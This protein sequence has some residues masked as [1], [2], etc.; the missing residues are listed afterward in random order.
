MT[1]IWPEGGRRCASGAD[2]VAFDD[3]RASRIAF[4]RTRASATAP[5]Q[6]AALF[7]PPR[8]PPLR[9]WDVASIECSCRRQGR[10][11]VACLLAGRRSDETQRCDGGIQRQAQ[12]EL[13]LI[14]LCGWHAVSTVLVGEPC[15][16]GL[17]TASHLHDHDLQLLEW[18]QHFRSIDEQPLLSLA[19]RWQPLDLLLAG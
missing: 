5:L 10:D 9:L 18:R 11:L 13:L 1:V 15:W 8:A 12:L 6:P 4:E 7:A 14:V 17:I 16:L 2:L 19:Q 3:A